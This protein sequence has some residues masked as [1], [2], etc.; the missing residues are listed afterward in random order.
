MCPKPWVQPLAP[1]KLGVVVTLALAMEWREARG[2]KAVG[3]VRPCLNKD[4]ACNVLISQAS[5]FMWA[6]NFGIV[7]SDNKDNVLVCFFL[8]VLKHS[9]P[10]QFGGGKGL[11]GS[12]STSQS[13]TEGS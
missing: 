8:S 4:K 9:D 1:H 2:S 10:K 11:I 6:I 13:V 3:Y 12:H 7:I 5:V